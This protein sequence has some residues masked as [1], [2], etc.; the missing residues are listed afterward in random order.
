MFTC[1]G[2]NGNSLHDNISEI[3]KTVFTQY[4]NSIQ[5]FIFFI[6]FKFFVPVL[7]AVVLQLVKVAFSQYFNSYCLHHC[8]KISTK[9]CFTTVGDFFN[10][11]ITVLQI[12]QIL[13]YHCW[14]GVEHYCS[15][16]LRFDQHAK[17]CLQ[18]HHCVRARLR[19]ILHLLPP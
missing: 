10:F 14:D 15:C 11:W 17:N 6:M 3:F 7:N 9:Y 5:T 1:K 12:V 2:N 18:L 13:F 19:P 4:S 16:V 8:S